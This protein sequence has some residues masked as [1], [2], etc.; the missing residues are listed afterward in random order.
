VKKAFV[1]QCGAIDCVTACLAMIC[2]CYKKEVEVAELRNM[3]GFD[4]RRADLVGMA[5]YTEKLGFVSRVVRV[6]REGLRSGFILPCIAD[7]TPTGGEP[8]FVVVYKIAGKCVTVGDPARGLVHVT[9]DEFVR[10]FAG[11][12][13]LLEPDNRSEMG[14]ARSGKPYSRFVKLLVPYKKLFIYAVVASLLLTILGIVSSLFNK[15]IMDEVLP[16]NLRSTLL[17]VA[18]VFIVIAVVQALISFVR[19]W[20]MLHLSQRIDIPLLLGYLEHVYRLPMK[21]FA[22]RKTG[23]IVTRFSDAFTIKNIFTNIALT[24]IM[25]VSMALVTGVI[26]FNMNGS[27]FAVTA[28]MTAISVVLVLGFRRPYKKG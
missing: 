10:D 2:L 1:K 6:D 20:M 13:L 25:D 8:H 14:E 27:L 17:P 24:V 3:V 19:Q 12:V 4:F 18:I 21:F 28:T 7:M 22:A 5:G 26:L 23:D 9:F 15:I 11:M 16:H